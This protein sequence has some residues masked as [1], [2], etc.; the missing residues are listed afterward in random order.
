MS[1][2]RYLLRLLPAGCE[3]STGDDV[4]A[5]DLSDFAD[6]ARRR[7]D[8]DVIV[9]VPG[10]SVLVTS[11]VVPSRQH[12]QIVQAIPF[13]V[14]E[15][16][17]SDVDD[18]HF[19]IGPRDADGRVNVCVVDKALMH[20]WLA[21]LSEA[22][23]QPKH[24]YPDTL[25][26]PFTG[27]VGITVDGDRAHIRSGPNRGFTVPTSQIAFAIELLQIS[28]GEIHLYCH[29]DQREALGIELAQLE[30]IEGITI[31]D[32]PTQTGG[33]ARL[34]PASGSID[35]LQGP[36]QKRQESGGRFRVWR[37]AAILAV[38]TFLIH[39]SLLLGQGIYLEVAAARY[40]GE[41]M[42]LYQQIFPNDRNVR[43]LRRRWN[44]H[45]GA[46]NGGGSEFLSLF[47]DAATGLPAA[48]L[49]VNNINYNDS[50][51]D[52]ILQLTAN[53][54]EQLVSYA[55]SLNQS[56]LDAE[57]GTISQQDSDV[58]GSIKVRL[59]GAGR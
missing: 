16:L 2:E 5:G 59:T 51:G 15:D 8:H 29:P 43:D 31:H 13:I 49:T 11:A 26:A 23:I 3:W 58:R 38:C 50:R 34:A 48:D 57:I 56:G 21:T 20:Q 42:A 12:R 40:E 14:E 24:L 46:G 6:E 7:P 44:A 45:I 32:H 36:F 9:A 33:L 39:V 30:A 52:L 53:R 10:E 37:S 47:Q 4:T 27:D 54:S 18:C 25:L 35:L 41:A 55:Q 19:A 22:G 28:S 1:T 17:A